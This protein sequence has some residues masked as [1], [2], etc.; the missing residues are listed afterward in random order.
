M[1]NSITFF[2]DRRG[3]CERLISHVVCDS[4]ISEELVFSR[5]RRDLLNRRADSNFQKDETLGGLL[6]EIMG[7]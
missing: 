3:L 1:G 7:P 2:Q 6:R 5:N 4:T